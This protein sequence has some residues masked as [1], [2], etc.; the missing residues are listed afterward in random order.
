[1]MLLVRDGVADQ[2]EK[3]RSVHDHVGRQAAASQRIAGQSTCHPI[4]SYRDAAYQYQLP[5]PIEPERPAGALAGFNPVLNP[6]IVEL[7]V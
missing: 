7:D 3:A 4:G 5:L 6:K 2:G 1:M